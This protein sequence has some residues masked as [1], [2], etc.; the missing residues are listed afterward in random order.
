M[1]LLRRVKLQQFWLTAITRAIVIEICEKNNIPVFE[2]D[3]SVTELYNADQV[4]TTGTMGELAKVIEIDNRKI[5]DVG[6]I[7]SDL[8]LLFN[9]LTEKEGENLPF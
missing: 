3:I 6:T 4:F 5:I 2:E 7:L 1:F 9:K 8:Q